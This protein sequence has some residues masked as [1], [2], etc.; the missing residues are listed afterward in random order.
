MAW[1][2]YFLTGRRQKRLISSAD[3]RRW[4]LEYLNIPEWLFEESRIAVGDSAETI[5]LLMRPTGVETSSNRTLADW[6]EKE[7]LPLIGVDEV[8]QKQKVYAWWASRAQ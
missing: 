6:V 2:I 7:I 4:A 8:E 3:I 5:S 1:A